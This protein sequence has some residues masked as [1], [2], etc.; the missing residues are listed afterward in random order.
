MEKVFE[1]MPWLRMP[2]TLESFPLTPNLRAIRDYA[3]KLNA[4]ARGKTWK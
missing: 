1:W 3:N 2:Q 4:K